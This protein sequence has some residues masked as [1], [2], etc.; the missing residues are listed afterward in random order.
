MLRSLAEHGMAILLSNS[1]AKEVSTD[2]RQQVLEIVP[3]YNQVKGR[4]SGILPV[5]LAN[6]HSYASSFK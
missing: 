3:E 5:D 2:W 6:I 4:Q 1:L